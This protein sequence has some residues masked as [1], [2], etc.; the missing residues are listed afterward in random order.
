VCFTQ[1]NP[2]THELFKPRCIQCEVLN[3]KI[4]KKDYDRRIAIDGEL[5][6]DT[7]ME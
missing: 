2:K 3:V 1:E 4:G 5:D 6:Y 7:E